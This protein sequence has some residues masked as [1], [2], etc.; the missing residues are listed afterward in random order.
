MYIAV[1]YSDDIQYLQKRN[2]VY[3]KPVLVIDRE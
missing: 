2:D 3:I 1:L